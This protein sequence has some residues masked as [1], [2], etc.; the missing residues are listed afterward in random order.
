MDEFERTFLPSHLPDEVLLGE[1]FEMLDIYLPLSAEHPHLRVRQ[2]GN[3]FEITKSTVVE[4]GDSSH[5]FENTIPLTLEEFNDLKELKG[6][7]VY[8]KRY[9]YTEAGFS[10]EIDVF[11]GDLEGLVLVDIEF[12]TKEEKDAYVPPSWVL[13]E[14]TQEEFLAGG[15][16]CGKTYGDIAARL[17]R[18]GYVKKHEY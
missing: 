12:K 13:I 15:M 7:R 5:Q 9:L 18:L 17:E 3:Q 8:K 14:V 1:C 6:K 10:Y 11:K 2:K 4:A 16:L